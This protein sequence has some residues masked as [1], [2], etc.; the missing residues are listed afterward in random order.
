MTYTV[1]VTKQGQISIPAQIRRKFGLE[2]RGKALVTET[3]EGKFLVEPLTDLLS[4]FGTVKSGK[5]HNLK[6]IRKEFENHL[7]SRTK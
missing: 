3:P 6:T 5:H 4:L 7:A 1:T 2:K